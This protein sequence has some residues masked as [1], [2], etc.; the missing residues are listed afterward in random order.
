M[1]K[2]EYIEDLVLE[3]YTALDVDIERFGDIAKSVAG[4][5]K[6]NDSLSRTGFIKLNA[7]QFNQLKSMTTK[8]GYLAVSGNA[9]NFRDSNAIDPETNAVMF[10]PKNSSDWCLHCF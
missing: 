2:I 10:T 1:E 8:S 6:F 4:V 9:I 3:P 5:I 7:N